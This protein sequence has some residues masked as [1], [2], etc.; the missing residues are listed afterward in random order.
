MIN[1][2]SKNVLEL[3]C[4][5]YNNNHFNMLKIYIDYIKELDNSSYNNINIYYNIFENKIF[6]TTKNYSYAL[7]NIFSLNNEK[8][9]YSEFKNT[10]EDQLNIKKNEYYQYLLKNDFE[11]LFILDQP[12][13]KIISWLLPYLVTKDPKVEKNDEQLFQGISNYI[14]KKFNENINEFNKSFEIATEDKSFKAQDVKKNLIDI[15]WQCKKTL[16]LFNFMLNLNYSYTDSGYINLLTYINKK[17]DTEKEKINMIN[18][19]KVN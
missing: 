17:F 6:C 5:E 1:N 4:D 12:F 14:I 13:D 8:L 10:F 7:F 11:K 18:K 15:M 16:Q 3:I 19:I 2:K 9:T